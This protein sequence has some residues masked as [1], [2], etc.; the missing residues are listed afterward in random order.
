MKRFLFTFIVLLSSLPF[1]TAVESESM[2]KSGEALTADIVLNPDQESASHVHDKQMKFQPVFPVYISAVVKNG[3]TVPS[4]PTTFF[5]RYAYPYPYQGALHSVLFETEK[6]E[7]PQIKAGEEVKI[8]FKKAHYLP[9][10]ADFVR[11][12]WPMRQYQAVFG[13]GD[14]ETIRGTLAL[15]YSAYYYPIKTND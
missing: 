10:I 7:L 11:H 13:N 12:E 14:Q 6:V 9:T 3:G 1:L 15:T 2:P 5:V 8:A 4:E